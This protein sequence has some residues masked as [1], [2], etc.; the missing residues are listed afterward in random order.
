MSLFLTQEL[1][2]PSCRTPVSFELV[3]SVNADRRP[4]LRVGRD[5]SPAIRSR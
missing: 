4:D 3:H 1:P 2:C 5:M